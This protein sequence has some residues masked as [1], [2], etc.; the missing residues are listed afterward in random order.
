MPK[1][2]ASLPSGRE[3]KVS[4]ATPAIESSIVSRS[5]CRRS[6]CCLRKGV[7]FTSFFGPGTGRPF[8]FSAFSSAF[9]ALAA[10]FGALF[11]SLEGAAFGFLS[12]SFFGCD[13]GMVT[14]FRKEKGG[15]D[16]HFDMP[17]QGEMG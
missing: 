8:G 5:N 11:S 12:A 1:A 6:R 17:T 9:G 13:F 3:R 10:A 15:R 16:T 2:L 4:F 14:G 7:S